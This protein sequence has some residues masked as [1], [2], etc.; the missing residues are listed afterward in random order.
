MGLREGVG[1]APFLTK[2]VTETDSQTYQC[3]AHTFQRIDHYI[4]LIVLE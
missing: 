2:V 4:Y 3:R 1:V